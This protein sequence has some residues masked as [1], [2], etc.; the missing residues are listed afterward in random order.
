MG[1]GF[2]I[3]FGLMGIWHLLIFAIALLPVILVALSDRVDGLTK[4]IWLLIVFWLPLL[5]LILFLLL[6]SPQPDD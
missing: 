3:G 2:D 1:M 4:L 6:T 5:G